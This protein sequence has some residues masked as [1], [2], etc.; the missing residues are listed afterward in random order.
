MSSR[1]QDAC[2]N[3]WVLPIIQGYVQS[4]RCEVN[5]SESGMDEHVLNEME[6]ETFDLLLISRR[7]V[8]R[9]GIDSLAAVYQSV[10]HLTQ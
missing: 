10:E 9:A 4:A 1:L 3:E 8:S 2:A 6:A 7:S 5:Y